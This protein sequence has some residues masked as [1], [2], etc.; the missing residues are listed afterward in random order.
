MKA[1]V[2]LVDDDRAADCL[3]ALCGGQN[4]VCAHKNG[5]QT[6]TTG[7]EDLAAHKC[8][9]TGTSRRVLLLTPPHSDMHRKIRPST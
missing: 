7:R 4:G 1:I 8:R 9:V 5:A 2:G 6:N 3:L